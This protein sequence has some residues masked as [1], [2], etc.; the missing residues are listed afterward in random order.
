MYGSIAWAS[1]KNGSPWFSNTITNTGDWLDPVQSH[2]ISNLDSSSADVTVDLDAVYAAWQAI[3][4]RLG[5][6]AYLYYTVYGPGAPADALV[7]RVT[8]GN[9]S[10]DVNGLIID[11]AEL[12]AAPQGGSAVSWADSTEVYMD[13]AVSD[14]SEYASYTLTASGLYADDG[15]GIPPGGVDLLSIPF[16]DDWE[17]LSAAT[18]TLTQ[19]NG[20]NINSLVYSPDYLAFIQA[21]VE[22]GSEGNGWAGLEVT[23]GTATNIYTYLVDPV[24]A[25]GEWDAATPGI[26]RIDFLLQS[27]VPGYTA[28]AIPFGATVNLLVR[29]EEQG[30]PGPT[31]P[32]GA[33]GSTGAT[34][35]GR[36]GA[37]GTTGIDGPL[38][39]TGLTGPTG[40]TGIAGKAGARGVAGPRGATGTAGVTGL[41]GPTGSTGPDP[42]RA[43]PGPRGAAGSTGTTGSTGIGGSLGGGVETVNAVGSQYL[44]TLT[45]E[46]VTDLEGLITRYKVGVKA[47]DRVL[48]RHPQRGGLFL[49]ESPSNPQGL[50]GIYGYPSPMPGGGPT[51]FGVPGVDRGVRF[52]IPQSNQ[53]PNVGLMARRLYDQRRPVSTDWWSIHNDYEE[54]DDENG[55]VPVVI[56]P[57]TVYYAGPAGR[58]GAA[59]FISSWTGVSY[60][61]GG[62]AQSMAMTGTSG[63]LGTG[64][65]DGKYVTSALA[66]ASGF[67]LGVPAISVGGVTGPTALTGTV[68]YTPSKYLT[69]YANYS[70]ELNSYDSNADTARWSYNPADLTDL[71]IG[72]EV[73]G[74][75]PGG[76]LLG[77]ATNELIVSGSGGYLP[78]ETAL[79]TLISARTPE[80]IKVWDDSR[81]VQACMDWA[82]VYPQD[83]AYNTNIGIPA[84]LS[85]DVARNTPLNVEMPSRG[86]TFVGGVFVRGFKGGLNFDGNNARIDHIPV[87]GPSRDYVVG[88]QTYT[89]KGLTGRLDGL[90]NNGV[91]PAP[92]RLSRTT[93]SSYYGE[94]NSFHNL[95]CFSVYDSAD[96]T[97]RDLSIVAPTS[98]FDL[99]G[100]VIMGVTGGRYNNIFDGADESGN[101]LAFSRPIAF[102]MPAA[103]YVTRTQN[104]TIEKVKK[105]W[106]PLIQQENAN[107]INANIKDLKGRGLV[108]NF[109]TSEYP[110]ISSNVYAGVRILNS[111][112]I[113]VPR[114]FTV[115]RGIA[116]TTRLEDLG[117]YMPGRAGLSHFFYIYGANEDSNGTVRRDILLRGNFFTGAANTLFKISGSSSGPTD[118]KLIGNSIVDYVGGDLGPSG[119]DLPTDGD[120]MSWIWKYNLSRSTSG[121]RTF[122]NQNFIFRGNLW[123]SLFQINPYQHQ[124]S[125]GGQNYWGRELQTFRVEDNV[126]FSSRV[127]F[128]PSEARNSIVGFI[129]NNIGSKRGSSSN[130]FSNNLMVYNQTALNDFGDVVDT[131]IVGQPPTGIR[132]QNFTSLDVTNNFYSE[133][134]N[135]PGSSANLNKNAFMI[136]DG[137]KGKI[138]NNYVATNARYT[139][140][141]DYANYGQFFS[142]AE[143]FVNKMPLSP[144][145]SNQKDGFYRGRGLYTSGGRRLYRYDAGSSM[146]RKPM[147]SSNVSTFWGESPANTGDPAGTAAY[148]HVALPIPI[149]ISGSGGS[150]IMSNGFNNLWYSTDRYGLL[151]IQDYAVQIGF[152]DNSWGPTMGQASSPSATFFYY[153]ERNNP[154][155]RVFSATAGAT[156]GSPLQNAVFNYGFN[157]KTWASAPKVAQYGW[158]ANYHWVP[159][160]GGTATPLQSTDFALVYL[161]PRRAAS[162]PGAAATDKAF[163]IDSNVTTPL[164]GYLV[165]AAPPISFNTYDG[166]TQLPVG[167][168]KLTPYVA[169]LG[170]EAQGTDY[171]SS[172]NP[173]R[174]HGLPSRVS[175]LVN[176]TSSGT[177]TGILTI[178]NL[179]DPDSWGGNEYKENFFISNQNA[180]T[181]IPVTSAGYP[182]TVPSTALVGTRQLFYYANPGDKGK[183]TQMKYAPGQRLRLSPSWTFYGS[184]A[185]ATGYPEIYGYVVDHSG[186]DL[187]GTVTLKI[188][189]VTGSWVYATGTNVGQGMTSLVFNGTRTWGKHDWHTLDELSD[190]ITNYAFD[191]NEDGVWPSD[192]VVRPFLRQ[193]T[194]DDG[195]LVGTGTVAQY[196]SLNQ[197]SVNNGKGKLGGI[198]IFAPVGS[199][200]RGSI[201]LFPSATASSNWST[202]NNG[203]YAKV[204]TNIESAQPISNNPEW[205]LTGTSW[206]GT[207]FSRGGVYYNSTGGT[208]T[209]NWENTSYAWSDNIKTET[210]YDTWWDWL[211][212]APTG[213]LQNP[214]LIPDYPETPESYAKY[215]S[216]HNA[217][218]GGDYKHQRWALFPPAG[219]SGATLHYENA[220]DNGVYSQQNHRYGI[221]WQYNNSYAYRVR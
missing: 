3:R 130:R 43:A 202:Y 134:I 50:S 74:I 86:H 27:N 145:V 117:R 103:F 221:A 31:G 211:G 128:T 79:L 19:P 150:G 180:W 85:D 160:L 154:A 67:L 4:D 83:R 46:D 185:A 136:L 162:V 57:T 146:P 152:I 22:Y 90:Y 206:T 61:N 213:H 123:S 18:I 175:L 151:G 100:R 91:L 7:Y 24:N 58:S 207:V 114:E 205:Q 197:S 82:M 47:G 87:P 20:N 73:R 181:L 38:G 120:H 81:A 159:S 194:K 137:T 104:M 42:G 218:P 196:S 199:T 176:I 119:A 13:W 214:M 33:T 94:A 220:A 26:N 71:R 198:M 186:G 173:L 210:G 78:G 172:N 149:Q 147:G 14:P 23:Y 177:G 97:F 95:A 8:F 89:W 70:T 56:G 209:P 41:T 195:V 88:G 54:Y 52:W 60:V 55:Q 66:T 34:G 106:G 135:N 165:I 156:A 65:Y 6:G 63:V 29:I 109:C 157:G 169:T 35:V 182:S 45:C 142:D 49:I 98:N 111:R 59:R 40:A 208:V 53:T 187:T 68:F 174:N 132:I 204:I 124:F 192:L 80:K 30:A 125:S 148:V 12:M 201:K 179:E 164:P 25:A 16:G 161:D 212:S 2:Y 51:I 121:V 219:V 72:M 140:A 21:Y 108:I 39:P 122:G 184:N 183:Q 102:D 93:Y 11:N 144:L 166:T 77:T 110:V 10:L 190:R 48:V 158:N 5:A 200:A 116:F 115:G 167:R 217:K 107:V 75:I 69:L 36:T 62:V 112:F 9:V 44:V 178:L 127:F 216:Y 96:V 143:P 139:N 76:T 126:F 92:P 129:A 37:T 188:D 28:T 1:L 101:S 138:R 168:Y 189:S 163:V 170:N 131:G 191:D 171:Y 32:T 99:Y 113:G 141:M 133:T 17:A 215:I 64:Y 193:F 153:E 105:R 118:I 15:T 203:M 84:D 155:L